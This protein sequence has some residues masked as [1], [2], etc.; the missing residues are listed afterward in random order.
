MAVPS[1]RHSF[2]CALVNL[3][4]RIGRADDCQSTTVRPCER[5][6]RAVFMDR[7]WSLS[8]KQEKESQVRRPLAASAVSIRL[9]CSSYHM[10]CWRLFG[11]DAI[12]NNRDKPPKQSRRELSLWADPPGTSYGSTIW[13]LW[14]LTV[15]FCMLCYFCTNARQT[16]H[17]QLTVHIVA[18]GPMVS[19]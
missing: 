18:Y 15:P 8:A 17:C 6:S 5:F 3:A 9:S 11:F 2:L 16:L 7:T 10:N 1:F 4:T 12:P 14:V 13:Y 19:S